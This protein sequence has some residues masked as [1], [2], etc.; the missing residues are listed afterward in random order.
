MQDPARNP[1]RDALA[2]LGLI[3]TILVLTLGAIAG[4]VVLG[5]HFGV[6]LHYADGISFF[7][8]K[9]PTWDFTNLWFGGRLALSGETWVLFDLAE[10][11]ARLRDIFGDSIDGSEWSYPPVILPFAALF[12]ALPLYPAHFLWTSLG[13]ALLAVT[14]RR[15]GIARRALPLLLIAPGVIVNV[16]FGQNGAVTASLLMLGLL[17]SANRP[18]SAGLAFG[19]LGFKPQMGLLAPVALA[20]AGRWRAFLF[21]ALALLALIAL[22]VALFGLGPWRGFFTVTQPLMTRILNAP[23]GQGYHAFA[24]TVF[25]F[26]RSLGAGLGLAYLVQGAVSLVVLLITVRLWRAP[27]RDAGLRVAAMGPLALL[28][29]PYGFAYDLAIITLTTLVLYARAGHRFGP[30]LGLIWLWPLYVSFYSAN[31]YPLTPFVLAALLALCLRAIARSEG[32]G[33]WRLVV[34]G[35]ARK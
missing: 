2:T 21:S 25:A 34:G 24:I 1:I 8:D 4:Y 29:T 7:A 20:A 3:W 11:R 22:S 33:A 19:L 5:L 17:A 35:L 18:A 30:L 32:T 15:L 31:T 23:Y 26:A 12:G 16:V 14:C 27:V 9:P 28:A 6:S 10:Y 13:L